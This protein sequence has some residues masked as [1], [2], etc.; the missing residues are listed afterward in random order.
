MKIRFMSDLHNEIPRRRGQPALPGG[1]IPGA[2]ADV[3]VFAGDIDNGRHGVDWAAEQGVKSGCPVIY[4][5]GNHEYYG[6]DF[7]RDRDDLVAHGARVGVHVLDRGEFTCG[8][9]RFLGATLWTDYRAGGGDRDVAM[10]DIGGFLNDHRCIRHRDRHFLTHDALREHET[11]VDWLRGRLAVPWD[12]PTVVVSHHGPCAAAQNPGYPVTTVTGA[13]WSDLEWL[14][15]EGV[16]L[17]IFGHTH[18]CVDVRIGATR[19]V[20]N[21]RGYIGIDDVP[22]FDA[23]RCVEVDSPPGG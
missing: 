3:L 14:M 8:P 22:G 10:R 7:P 11:S 6:G 17:W 13:F 19:V 1:G 23:G 21:Q 2:G 5:P 4:V 15:G 18:T 12:G 20:S 16:D 9:V